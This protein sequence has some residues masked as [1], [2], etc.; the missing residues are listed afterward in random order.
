[1]RKQ[2]CQQH[3]K[4][5][6]TT[7][8]R[9]RMVRS[10]CGAKTRVPATGL[11]STSVPKCRGKS[12]HSLIHPWRRSGPPLDHQLLDV[13]DR[14]GRI[15]ALGAGLGTVHDGMTAVQAEGVFEIVE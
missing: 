7:L 8:P 3:D 15:E 13:G 14:L 9:G 1:M 2:Q 10:I 5:T 12:A 6:A 4:T 11:T